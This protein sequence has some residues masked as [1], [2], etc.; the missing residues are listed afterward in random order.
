MIRIT[1]T[2][3]K[4]QLFNIYHDSNQALLWFESLFLNQILRNKKLHDWNQNYTW[5]KSCLLQIK[6]FMVR[7]NLWWLLGQ[8]PILCT[9]SIYARKMTIFKRCARVFI[10][11]G[12]ITKVINIRINNNTP[13]RDSDTLGAFSKVIRKIKV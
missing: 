11:R 5:F 3:M 6:S 12:S 10:I 9:K 4:F 2:K 7:I 1:Y 8:R 13:L